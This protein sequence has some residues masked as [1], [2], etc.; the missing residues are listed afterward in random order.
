MR[1]TQQCSTARCLTH[2]PAFSPA[3]RRL[4]LRPA[5]SSAAGGACRQPAPDAPARARSV[6]RRSTTLI[7]VGGEWLLLNKR[8]TPTGFVR[9]PA[10]SA[11]GLQQPL[12]LHAPAPDNALFPGLAWMAVWV[13][14]YRPPAATACGGPAGPQ[15]KACSGRCHAQCMQQR[16]GAAQA[17]STRIMGRTRDARPG[18]AQAAILLMVA[19]AVIAGLTDLTYSL[20]GYLW[21]S[22]CA[23]STAVYL[24][25]IRLLKDRTGAPRRPARSG[26][27]RR[28][29]QRRARATPQRGASARRLHAGWRPSAP[30]RSCRGRALC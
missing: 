27:L 19:G 4:L 26:G 20:P 16:A 10:R 29:Q 15:P 7:V 21:V 13:T 28:Q 2:T 3:S 8:P 1:Q 5:A 6:F 24:L 22:V 11:R 9:G 23:V 30:R 25:L 14:H 18:A 17:R 12:A